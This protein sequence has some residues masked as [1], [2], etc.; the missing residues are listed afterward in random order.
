[1]QKL[2]FWKVARRPKWIGGLVVA[3]LVAVIFS[4]L[5]QWQLSRT[6]NVVG[7]VIEENTPVPLND[8]VQPGTLQP[9]IFDRQAF[10]T[11]DVDE[12]HIYIVQDRLQLVGQESVSGYWLVANSVTQ[13][14]EKPVS[15][16]LALGFARDLDSALR[17]KAELSASELEVT[18]YIQPT[19]APEESTEPQTLGSL[20]LAQLVNF[21][22]N[23]PFASYPVYLIVQDGIDVGLE[24]ISIGILQQQIE[25]N[26]LTLF[27]AIEWAFFALVAFYLWGRLVMDE[28]NRE[29][30]LA[31]EAE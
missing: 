7:T 28:R 27:Y 6:F 5:M 31:L 18:G 11:T 1:M 4:V 2:S 15:L 14:D 17:A 22:S 30:E 20:S 13:V 8:L 23:E 26:W 9:F 16:T 29:I 21:Y 24:T 25:V 12:E 19:E 3:L 10:V